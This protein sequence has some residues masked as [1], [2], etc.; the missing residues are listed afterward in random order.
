MG[1]LR[2]IKKSKKAVSPVVSTVLLIVIVIIIALIILLWARG[3]LPEIL[4][5]FG[6]PIDSSC[7]ELDFD[8]SIA[9][10]SMYISNN[11]NIPIYK[12][13]IKKE[14]KAETTSQIEQI[15]LSIG[16]SLATPIKINDIDDYEKLKIIPILLAR[17]DQET[18]EYTC[19]ERF[20]VEC[21]K[22]DDSFIC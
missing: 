10:T 20:S 7:E 2:Q 8:V 1:K 4:E 18:K 15:D 9:G 3:F 17:S 6:K 12:I 21:V 13:D 11:G 19:N 22:Q 14:T 5:K 16:A